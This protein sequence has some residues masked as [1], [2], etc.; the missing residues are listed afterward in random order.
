MKI[1]LSSYPE[2]LNPIFFAR[3]LLISFIFFILYIVNSR[4]NFA[5]R[6]SAF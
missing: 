5:K 2:M 3:K 4:T 6:K 1:Y